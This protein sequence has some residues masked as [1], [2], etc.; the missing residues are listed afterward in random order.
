MF[1]FSK[2]VSIGWRVTFCW[3]QQRLQSYR[4]MGFQR[5]KRVFTLLIRP[6]TV[7]L[8]E[9]ESLLQNVIT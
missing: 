2:K 5:E 6:G 3:Q 1:F 7:T 4:N 8:T 9:S